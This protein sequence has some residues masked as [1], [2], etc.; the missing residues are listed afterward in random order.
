M[1]RRMVTLPMII[2]SFAIMSVMALHGSIINAYAGNSKSTGTVMVSPTV[3]RLDVKHGS[4]LQ[5]RMKV[6]NPGDSPVSVEVYAAPY[7]VQ[8]EEY[9]PTFEKSDARNDIVRWI[10][11]EQSGYTLEPQES[12]D[13]EFTIT[14]PESI[15]SGGQYAAIFAQSE[16][17][18][19]DGV[20]LAA[21][22]GMLLYAHTDG[23]TVD[24]TKYLSSA[25]PFWLHTGGTI[26][27]TARF[28]NQ[29]NSD[30]TGSGSLKAR[31]MLTGETVFNGEI[32]E[33][34]VLPDTTR[35][36]HL[37]W[38]KNLPV[39]GLFEL[40]QTLKV[41]DRTTERSSTLVVVP[42]WLIIMVAVF[43]STLVF[44]VFVLVHSIRTRRTSRIEHEQS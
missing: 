39:A 20:A 17:I 14:V 21:R 37:D 18:Q 38:D 3:L 27:T 23:T 7:S 16:Q 29:G 15:P 5:A 42:W 32:V 41:N 30:A 1:S 11:F 19:G 10:T 36:L 24:D 44:M 9:E 6:T 40:T 33:K 31:N 43:M 26:S 4:T 25:F 34:S 22:A 2:L 8:G 12:V 35:A 13:V 28:I